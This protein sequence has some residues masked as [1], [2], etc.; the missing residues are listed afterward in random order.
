[1]WTSDADISGLLDWSMMPHTLASPSPRLQSSRFLVMGTLEIMS[2]H[3]L[4]E[5][6]PDTT[7]SMHASHNNRVSFKEYVIPYAKRQRDA[8]PW[9]DITSS[10]SYNKC[11]EWKSG[12]TSLMN[13]CKD[14]RKNAFTDPSL[15][16][17]N[18]LLR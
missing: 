15:L 2:L 18:F 13:K 14:L 17:K 6:C 5:Q 11:H 12:W 1:M 9:V 7:A 3:H 4:G 16:K 8:L 10:T